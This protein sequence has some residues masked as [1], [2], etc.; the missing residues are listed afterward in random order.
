M[1]V[2][3]I[4]PRTKFKAI[5]FSAA[6]S[7]ECIKRLKMALM[8]KANYHVTDLCTLVCLMLLLR[9]QSG[10]C[11]EMEIDRCHSG[12][13]EPEYMCNKSSWPWPAAPVNKCY[14]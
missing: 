5:I 10:R 6:L 14:S 12:M 9:Y 11:P 8:L 13:T 4:I 1:S 2:S 3:H 7:E